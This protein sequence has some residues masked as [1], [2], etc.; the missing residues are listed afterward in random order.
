MKVSFLD[1]PA[2]PFGLEPLGLE[3]GA[4]RL[5]AERKGSG[6]FATMVSPAAGRFQLLWGIYL[7]LT[8][9]FV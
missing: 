1:N 5:M 8:Y 2:A 6:A 9:S 3:L 7:D 4:E